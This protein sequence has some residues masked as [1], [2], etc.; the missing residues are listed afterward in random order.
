M[1]DYEVNVT[2][3]RAFAR[4]QPP[5]TERPEYSNPNVRWS[6][7]AFV[8]KRKTGKASGWTF[9]QAGPFCAATEQGACSARDFFIS[10]YLN[11]RKRTRSKNVE[12]V[13]APPEVPTLVV[14]NDATCAQADDRASLEGIEGCLTQRPKRKAAPSNLRDISHGICYGPRPGNERPGPGRGHVLETAKAP[15]LY[16]PTSL[17]ELFPIPDAPSGDWLRQHAQMKQWRTERMDQQIGVIRR[18]E[19]NMV[20]KDSVIGNQREEILKLRIHV[21]FPTHFLF[22][23]LLSPLVNSFSA[24]VICLM[25]CTLSAGI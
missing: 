10:E 17:D 19:A 14:A 9:E 13:A 22:H 6:C 3:S 7:R 2:D 16:V 1:E 15:A 20:L 18:L 23:V 5:A 24:F 11:P 25:M 4:Q 8:A 21:T 12:S